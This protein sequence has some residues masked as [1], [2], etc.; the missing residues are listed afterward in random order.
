[1]DVKMF[2]AQK[3]IRMMDQHRTRPCTNLRRR[4][5]Q[6]C[7]QESSSFIRTC[8]L[9]LSHGCKNVLSPKGH[10]NDGPTYSSELNEEAFFLFSKVKNKLAGIS[11]AQESLKSV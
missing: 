8:L 2:S 7:A 6:R 5:G 11:I 9:R 1:M 4:E 10:P 3:S